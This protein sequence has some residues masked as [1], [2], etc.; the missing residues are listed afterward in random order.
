MN[1][2]DVLSA[3][4][5]CEATV[6]SYAPHAVP[7]RA[8]TDLIGYRELAKLQHVLWMIG[9]A[10]EFVTA[11]RT[12]KAFRWLGFVQGVLWSLGLVTIEEAKESNRP[13]PD[14]DGFVG[15]SS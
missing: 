1:Q 3:L 5:D 4:S 14:G 2:K 10:R 12:E 7:L 11:N 8:A 6:K 13:K 15:C 9:Q